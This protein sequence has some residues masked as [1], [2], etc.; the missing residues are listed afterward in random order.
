MSFHPD[1]GAA[2]IEPADSVTGLRF[3]IT[4]QNGG[5]ALIDYTQLKP[6]RLALAVARALRQLG[7]SGGPLTVRS[8]V[9]AYAVTLPRFFAYLAQTRNRIGGPE[10]LRAHHVDGFEAWLEAEGL[11]RTH[12]FNVLVKVVATLR[13]IAA[14]PDA[15]ISP[16]LR[17]RLRYV[18]AR[19]F[20]RARPRDAYSPFVARQLRDA[21]RADVEGLFRRFGQQ[22][23]VEGDASLHRATKAVE[24]VIS[25]R[26]RIG[27]KHPALKSLY[28]IRMRR[29]LPIST[30]IEELHAPHHLLA[31]DL[32]PLLVL[33]SLET[34]LE[35]E[36]CKALTID[37]LRNPSAGTIAV[38]YLKRRAHGA[39]HKSLRVRDG[40]IGTPGGLIRRLIEV[41]AMA[42][43]HCPS[44]NL[45]VYLRR[46]RL[47]SGIDHWQEMTDVWTRRHALVD[48]DGQP[49]RLLLS[50]LRKTHKALW[51][52]KTEGHMARFAVG[53]TVEVAA[54]HYADIPSFRP[55]HEATVAD[56]FEEAVAAARAPTLLSP[57]QEAD[58]RAAPEHAD[59]IVAPD[60]VVP[61]LD[62]DQ[63]VWLASCAGFYA[64]PHGQPG[65]PC[66][67]P[68]WGCLDCGNAVITAR[69]LPAILAFLAFTEAERKG[70]AAS[71]WH[72]KFGHVHARITSQVLPAFS[73]TVIAE[74]R[75]A[76]SMSPLPLYLP[77]EVR[78]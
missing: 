20:Q 29:E 43:R 61:L 75:A 35:L 7:A 39:E 40:G 30:L 55:L 73:E 1:D 25:E 12:L 18:S 6:R 34:G 77:P 67:Q 33:L 49:L 60:A 28:S 44:D 71:D 10:D 38:T 23:A 31:R 65:E 26:G 37:C 48:D 47:R 62:G 45:W 59:G 15:Q 57:E 22:S 13:R 69:K 17:N 27:H 54:R 72:A 16:D 76:L 3:T 41:T 56:A 2:P 5:D 36:C 78:A 51:Y 8:T 64:S 63:D 42:R 9:K 52:R 74:A 66:P 70:L 68:F 24:A 4:A 50:R 19:P 14:E 46:G 53:H 21:A 11:S 32:P 58:W